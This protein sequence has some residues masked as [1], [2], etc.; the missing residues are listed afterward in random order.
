MSAKFV[1]IVDYDLENIL[2]PCLLLTASETLV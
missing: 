1:H 2:R